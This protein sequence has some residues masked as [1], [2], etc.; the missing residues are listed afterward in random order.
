MIAHAQ[1]LTHADQDALSSV[2]AAGYA[3]GSDPDYRR[4]LVRLAAE[5]DRD[6][7]KET[8]DALGIPLPDCAREGWV[9]S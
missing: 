6:I 2:W 5:C 9:A 8:A 3:A 4:R 1:T 7:A